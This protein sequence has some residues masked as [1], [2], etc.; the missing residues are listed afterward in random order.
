[1]GVG[2]QRVRVIAGKYRGRTINAPKGDET[3]PTTDRVRESVFSSL[4]SLLGAE[5]GGGS[6]LDAF[7]GSGALGIEALS[8]GCRSA[9]FVES[10][11]DAIRVLRGNLDS[12]GA[13]GSA[14]I[15]QGDA[16]SLA[17]RCALP[18]APFALLLLDPPY[19]LAPTDIEGFTSALARCGS[20]ADEAVIVYEHASHAPVE[21]CSQF[22]LV[23]RKKYG[24]TG[25]DIVAY[26]K[27]R[28]S[29]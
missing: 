12:L 27:G 17:E 29:S 8:R 24:S 16:L 4:V 7:A 13:S 22:D 15:V 1:M 26:Q 3:R 9:T 19:R 11:R 2:E 21:W 23:T 14:R 28:G 18:G 6:V 5:L 25:I 20:I 10:S